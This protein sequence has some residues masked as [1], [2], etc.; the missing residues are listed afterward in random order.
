MLLKLENVKKEYK[1]NKSYKE[2]IFENLNLEFEYGEFVCILGESGSGKSTLL[3]MIGALDTNYE[4][5]IYFN[6]KNLKDINIDSYRKDNI[7]FIFQNFNLISNLTVLENV[8]LK[9]N[10]TKMSKKEKISIAKKY[11]KKLGIENVM[12]KKPKYLSGGQKQRVAI[13]RALVTNPDII[14]AD[15]PTGALDFINSTKILEIL[16]EISEEGKLVIVVTHSKKVLE[17]SNRVIEIKNRQ[18]VKDEKDKKINIS[19][20]S[21]KSKSKKIS[22]LTSIKFGFNNIIKNF[23]RNLLIA[24]ASSIGIVGVILCLY[25]GDGVKKFID[26][27]INKK[28]NPCML[29]IK[30]K[31]TNELYE[32][33]YYKKDEISKLKKIKNVKNI[34]E[35]VIYTNSAALKY[36]DKKYDLVSFSTYNKIKKENILYGDENGIIISKYLADKLSK[37]KN[38]KDILNKEID[39][40]IL[41]N[42]TNEPFLINEKIKISGIYKKEKISL[43]DDTTYAYISYKILNNLYNK[44]NKELLSNSVSIEV[45]NKNNIDLVTKDIE[46]NNYE[47]SNSSE[48]IDTVY[49]YLDIA[50]F[51]L[52]GLSFISLIVSSIMIIIVMHINVVERTKEI[53]ILRALGARKKDIKRIFKCESFVLGIF[54]GILSSIS[55]VLLSNL[56]RK[57]IF[58]N[59]KIK[60]ININMEFLIIG[61]LLSILLT[62]ISS[63]I[64]SSKA[65]KIDPI[66]ALRYE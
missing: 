20:D 33:D 57:I 22:F 58:N 44:N 38:Y 29:D 3:N 62:L 23:K 28:I 9:L 10:M 60:F 16:K 8:L 56:I 32:V 17:Y 43:I 59:F 25:I 45:N 34:Y 66:E 13:A 41:D 21:N 14:I 11:I 53:G 24:V 12:N 52:A 26:N 35:G 36:N 65:S 2:T 50:T 30:K 64:P 6:N 5:N 39:I 51:I 15:E 37:E 27:E 48:I 46:K 40:F 47:V 18:V 19:K 1:V 42:S 61:V 31:G 63:L 54:I 7:S 4:G 55:S 49:N